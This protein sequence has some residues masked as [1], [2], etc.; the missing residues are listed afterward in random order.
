MSIFTPKKKATPK[1]ISFKVRDE[2]HQ[3][4]ESLEKELNSIDGDLEFN[5]Q[6]LLADFFEKTLKKGEKELISQKNK[7][8]GSSSDDSPRFRTEP[9]A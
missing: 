6:D 9:D 4:L 2:L 1:T 3:R 5:Y 8:S 7:I